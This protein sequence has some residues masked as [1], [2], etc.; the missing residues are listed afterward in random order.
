MVIRSKEKLDKHLFLYR[1]FIFYFVNFTTTLKDKDSK[2]II[3]AL[4]IKSR[5]RRIYFT[6]DKVCDQ[7]DNYYKNKNL[8]VFSN[9]RCICHRSLNLDYINGCCR[10][11]I[12]QSNNGCLSKNFACKMFN[13]S[14]VK[15]RYKTINYSDLK[16]LNVLTPLQRMV[17][18]SDFFSSIDEV[19]KDLYF[20]PIYSIFRI[21]IRTFKTTFCNRK[22]TKK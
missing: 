1:S 21:S 5:Y 7:I 14:Y 13:C 11:C 8:C 9:C 12:Y 6:I 19:S 18:K 2:L 16:L 15:D 17:L 4:N 10:K 22:F 20:G 3:D